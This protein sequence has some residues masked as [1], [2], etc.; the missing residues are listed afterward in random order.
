M[1]IA[2]KSTDFLIL[3]R[4]VA[5]SRKECCNHY[6]G[7]CLETDKPCHLVGNY[8]NIH[9]GALNCDWFLTAVLPQDRELHK[10]VRHQMTKEETLFEDDTLPAAEGLVLRCCAICRKEFLPV[11]HNQKYC[12]DCRAESRRQNGRRRTQRFRERKALMKTAG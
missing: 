11:V 3:S 5:L 10:I 1:A 8:P 2:K 6:Q 4:C 7:L 9:D 12:A